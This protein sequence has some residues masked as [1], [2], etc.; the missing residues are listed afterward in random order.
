MANAL[1]EMASEALFVVK[2]EETKVKPSRKNKN[3]LTV[4]R[5]T[6]FNDLFKFHESRG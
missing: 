5:N 2:E 4:D 3:A 6:F 1:A